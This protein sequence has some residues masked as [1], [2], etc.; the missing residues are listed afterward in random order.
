MD[1]T[2]ENA[3]SFSISAPEQIR[4]NAIKPGATDVSFLLGI[5]VMEKIVAN[6]YERV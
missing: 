2:A 3:D 1:T 6:L 5:V 4:N